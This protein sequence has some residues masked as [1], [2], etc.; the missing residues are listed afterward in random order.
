VWSIKIFS[1]ILFKVIEKQLLF[2]HGDLT[3]VNT[4]VKQ[5]ISKIGVQLPQEDN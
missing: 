4:A 3:E 5:T 2:L 1:I